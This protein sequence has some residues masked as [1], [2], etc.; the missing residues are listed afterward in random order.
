ML[1]LFGLTLP[2]SPRPADR[3]VAVA[4]AERMTAATS[5]LRGGAPAALSAAVRQDARRY[6]AARRRGELRFPGGAARSCDESAWT[7]MRLTVDA[8]PVAGVA[9][10]LVA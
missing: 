7:L 8:P 4:L 3:E 10:R 1:Q 6:L 9:E 2:E 5:A